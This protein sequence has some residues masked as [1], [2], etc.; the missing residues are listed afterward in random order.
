MTTLSSDYKLNI[1]TNNKT[2]TFIDLFANK[3]KKYFY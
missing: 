3:I 2:Y 1:K